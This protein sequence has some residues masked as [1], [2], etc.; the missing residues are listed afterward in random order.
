MTARCL[1][2]EGM[3]KPRGTTLYL[4]HEVRERLQAHADRNRQS[5]S[6]AANLLLTNALD[7]AELRQERRA[8]NG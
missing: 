6:G 4:D 2:H 3:T 7:D 5:M 8:T 1:Y